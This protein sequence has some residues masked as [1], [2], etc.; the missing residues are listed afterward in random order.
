MMLT[1]LLITAA[2]FA[3]NETPAT[4]CCPVVE[5]RQYTVLPGRRD[6]FTTM[7]ER[8]FIETQESLGM[9]VLGQ[10]RDLDYPNHFVWLRGFSGMSVRAEQLQ[11][12]YGGPIWKAH[13]EEAN[14]NFTDTDNVLLLQAISATSQFDVAHAKRPPM[15]ALAEQRGMLVATIYY[16]DAPVGDDFVGFF[17][18]N[19]LPDLHRSGITPIAAF[20]SETEPN[21]FPRLPVREKDHVFVWFAMYDDSNDFAKHAKQLNESLAWKK[22]AAELRQRLNADPQTLRLAPAPR[23]LLHR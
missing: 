15:G 4:R 3:A 16:F 6:P 12:F 1:T 13:R 17:N 14:A 20:R 22:S 23:S 5:L 8:E 7:F 21:N 11:A 9:H 10:F 19:L 18:K 2:I